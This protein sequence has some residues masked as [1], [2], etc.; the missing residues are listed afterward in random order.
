MDN[1]NPMFFYSTNNIITYFAVTAGS[2]TSPGLHTVV[3]AMNNL[4]FKL[5]II[6]EAVHIPV[7]IVGS[8]HLP[9]IKGMIG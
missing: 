5:E 7:T 9:Y 6:P 1:E 8:G 4:E 3:K 2:S